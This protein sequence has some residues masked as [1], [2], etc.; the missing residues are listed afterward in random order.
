AARP[1]AP[2][3][4]ESARAAGI[5][6]EY[7][8]RRRTAGGD[9]RQCHPK[10]RQSCRAVNADGPRAARVHS[11]RRGVERAVK[12]SRDDALR[13]ASEDAERAEAIGGR[14]H[15]VRDRYGLVGHASA[16]GA[17]HQLSEAQIAVRAVY[18]YAR[19]R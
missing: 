2:T 1:G 12:V 10:G 17:Q 5:L 16:A 14:A 8:V 7:A 15:A 18:G 6:N 3:A 13:A 11:A 19:A 4:R 9:F